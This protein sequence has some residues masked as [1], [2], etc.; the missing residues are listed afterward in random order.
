MTG[1]EKYSKEGKIEQIEKY[2]G[3]VCDVASS[4]HMLEEK[5]G[6]CFHFCLYF[7]I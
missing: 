7:H 2:S 5:D 3:G 4:G 6:A 1:P